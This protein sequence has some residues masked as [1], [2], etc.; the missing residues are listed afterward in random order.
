[1]AVLTKDSLTQYTYKNPPRIFLGRRAEIQARYDN[2]SK[3]TK[4]AFIKTVITKLLS[5]SYL[6]VENDFPYNV[7]QG[8]KHLLLFSNNTT[9]FNTIRFMY[10]DKL[11]TFWVN[12]PNNCSIK[13]VPHAHIFVECD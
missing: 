9:I 3:E 5:N 10:G 1:M 7:E 4:E 11:I 2:S 8:I 12:M 13:L 6:I